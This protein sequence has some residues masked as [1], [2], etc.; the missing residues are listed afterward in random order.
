[1][2]AKKAD[3]GIENE[4]PLKSDGSPDFRTKQARMDPDLIAQHAEEKAKEEQLKNID[5][6]L[7]KNRNNPEVVQAVYG[8]GE[9]P[10]ANKKSKK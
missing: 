7:D 2:T 8:D 9:I 10:N 4:I 5:M 3:Q 1:M 6:R